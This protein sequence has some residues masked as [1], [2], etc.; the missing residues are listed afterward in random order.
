[1]EEAYRLPI[2]TGSRRSSSMRSCKLEKTSRV[3]IRCSNGHRLHVFGQI[4]PKSTPLRDRDNVRIRGE[5]TIHRYVNKYPE[6][7]SSLD[8]PPAPTWVPVYMR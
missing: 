6:R 5:A 3:K 7:S 4:C 1:M 8:W 2:K